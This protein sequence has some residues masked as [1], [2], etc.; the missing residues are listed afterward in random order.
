[1]PPSREPPSNSLY[2]LPFRGAPSSSSSTGRPVRG[3]PSIAASSSFSSFSSK[4]SSTMNIS[5][6]SSNRLMSTCNQFG[7]IDNSGI[8]KKCVNAAFCRSSI[9]ASEIDSFILFFLFFLVFSILYNELEEHL[10][11]NFS[12]YNSALLRLV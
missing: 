8:S 1:M 7:L 2:V 6:Y 10:L 12:V 4:P 5:L 11:S 9:C 3:R